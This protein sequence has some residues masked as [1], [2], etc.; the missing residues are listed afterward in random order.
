M[1]IVIV[2]A[3]SVGGHLARYLSGEQMD[4]VI[5][6]TDIKKLTMLNIEHN[7]MTIEGDGTDET[8]LRRAEVDRCDIFV[9]VTNIAERNIVACGLAKEMGAQITVA[10]V[11]HDGYQNDWNVR[12]FRKMGVDHLIFPELLFARGIIDSLQHS[13]A[14]EWIEFNNG[15]IIMLGVRVAENAPL[16]GHCLKEL[17]HHHEL[18]HVAAARRNMMTLIP[19]GNYRVLANDVLYVVTTSDHA[20]DV[21][22]LTGNNPFGIKKVIIAGSGPVVE[23]TLLNS[24]NEFQFTVVEN[25]MSN[26]RRLM[27]NCSGCEIIQGEPSEMS[28]LQEAGIGRAQAFVALTDSSECNILIS[29]KA[30]ELGVKKTIARVERWQ[31]YSMAESF[32]I[33]TIINKQM[34]VANAIFQLLIDEA[35]LTTKCLVLPDAEMVRTEVKAGS[36]ITK[37][38][39]RELK[40]PAEITFA[41]LMRNGKGELVTGHTH[42]TAGDQVLVVCLQGALQNARKLF[43]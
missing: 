20:D 17:P 14:D 30:R 24:S 6:D 4:I 35:S 2:G 41:A 29:L 1:R 33:G 25:D 3:G 27:R 8:T 5:I 9:S 28:V 12:V 38:P 16:A 42:F 22:R 15:R 11:N 10:S 39:V 19:N 7:L 26:V 23:T 43:N 36:R 40:I 37:A 34:L 21:A 13:W 32:G 31:F 18:L